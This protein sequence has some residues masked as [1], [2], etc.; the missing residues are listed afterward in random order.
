MSGT[1]SKERV[2]VS[3]AYSGDKWA[4]KVKKMSDTQIVAIFKRLR[5][6]GRI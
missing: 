6:Q 2:A 1:E 3:Q 5:E 4:A